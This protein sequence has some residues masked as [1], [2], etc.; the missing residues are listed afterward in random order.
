VLSGA[1]LDR[2]IQDWDDRPA[3]PHRTVSF[4]LVGAAL[5]VETD[6]VELVD[7]LRVALG[8]PQPAATAA[9][10]LTLVARVRTADGRGHVRLCSARAWDAEDL[11]LGLQSPEFPFERR[12]A[13][14]GWLSLGFRGE[15]EPFLSFR[16]PDC[17]FALDPRWRTGVA[18]FLFHRLLRMRPD[19][20]FFH[21]AS[22][23]LEG[24]GVLLVG[25]K[26]FGKSTTALALAAR[27]HG[28][29][30][31]ET[32]AY[33]PAD[34]SLLPLRRPVGIK[35]GPRARAVAEAV[36][37]GTVAPSPDGILRVDLGAL[38]PA[39]VPEPAPLRAVLFLRGFE[40]APRLER[41]EPGR[42]ELA[43][44][45][46]LASSLV[47]APPARRVFEM[48]RLLAGVSVYALRPGDPDETALLL[49]RT[50]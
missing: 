3:L 32:A 25:P 22:V 21:A 34:R 44:L 4:A 50:L 17:L 35:P 40:P 46:P 15:P 16:G 14:P 18:L 10:A 36:A 9:E 8:D 37:Q 31:D 33:Q 5:R 29:L 2:Q 11:L 7:R 45:Q 30:G 1:V 39:P 42:D 47:D 28:L 19:L 13:D 26:G 48:A 24:R 6:D 23:V 12:P 38:W 43:A 41:I 20:L 27:G 49:E